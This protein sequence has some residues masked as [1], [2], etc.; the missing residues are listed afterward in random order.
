MTADRGRRRALL[1]AVLIVVV[2]AVL[3]SFPIWLPPYYLTTVIR[4]LFYSMLAM[5]LSFLAGQGG[6]VS[7]TQTGLFGFSAYV[8]AILSVHYGLPFP[9]PLLIALAGTLGLAFVFGIISIRTYGTYFLI[10]TLALGQMVWAIAQQWTSVT[11]GFDGIQG[12]RAPIIGGLSFQ[13]PANFYWV[14]LVV[15]V[16]CFVLLRAVI[17]SPFGLAMRGMRDSHLRMA[18]L[19]YSVP[20]IRLTAFMIAAVPAA[21]AGTFFVQFTGIVTPAS[22]DLDRTVWILLIVILGGVGSLGGTVVGVFIAL[23]FEVAVTRFTDRYL[24]A[25][26]ITFLLLVLFAPNGLAGALESLQ[27][28]VRR[29]RRRGSDQRAS[30]GIPRSDPGS[31]VRTPRRR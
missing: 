28:R 31:E 18:A 13:V 9:Y 22:L 4:I 1:T 29:G 11:E 14:L 23:M 3:V 10:L 15:F 30:G 25:M 5:S 20:R 2:G 21:V 6:M 26:G 12:T 7:L 27:R 17:R 16:A 19:G 8:L 24:T